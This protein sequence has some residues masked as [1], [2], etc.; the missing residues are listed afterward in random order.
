MSWTAG[1][2]TGTHFHT[3]KQC[4]PMAPPQQRDGAYVLQNRH[5]DTSGLGFI[6]PRWELAGHWQLLPVLLSNAQRLSRAN[7]TEVEGVVSVWKELKLFAALVGL[8]GILGG[9]FSVSP[10][11][12]S[13]VG[14]GGRMLSQE[15]G[16]CAPAASLEWALSLAQGVHPPAARSEGAFNRESSS[17]DCTLDLQ[18]L[19]PGKSISRAHL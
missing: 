8:W 10:L 18:K 5:L 6:A 1:S 11:P 14:Q 9:L 13:P 12:I 15:G 2:C 4:H 19:T 17:G 3:V 7:A 16:T